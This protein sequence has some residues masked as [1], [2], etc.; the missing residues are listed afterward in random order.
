MSRI[1]KITVQNLKAISELSIDFNGCTAIITGKNNSGKSSFLKTMVD[2]I[3][4]LKP[5]L[6][7]KIGEKVGWGEIVLTT[8]EK[9]IWVF[10]TK[11]DK[12][13]YI[14]EKDIK[15]SLTKDIASY[16][17]PKTFDVDK[18]LNS[19]P[20]Q[21]KEVLEKLTGIEFS[22]INQ[23]LEEAVEQRKFFNKQY[24]IEQAK[25]QYINKEIPTEL[26]STDSL[27]LELNS[28]E[29]H[30]LQYKQV[31]KEVYYR[32]EK[33]AGNETEIS[34]LEEMIK[35]LRMKNNGIE[36]E[37]RKGQNWL[38][39]DIN[40]PKN[41]K[42]QLEGEIQVIKEKNKMI[43]ENNKAREQDKRIDQARLNAENLDMEVKRIEAEKLDVIHNSKMPEGFG[44]SENGITYNGFDFTKEQLSS[45]GIY[46]AA[47]KL[48]A[49][50]LG[51]V[52]TLHFDASFL[53]KNSLGEIEK[54][55]EDN[56]LQL[57]IERPDFEGGEITYE[58]I[59]NN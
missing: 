56:S 49:I 3:K 35:D 13:T 26:I 37:I 44:F 29:V 59:Q 57:L 47:L 39:K 42:E 48:A 33:K 1:K 28:I 2:R 17:F 14:T 38:D 11:G 43:E 40:K 32:K 51:E 19:P 53:D 22:E 10:D 54:W 7:L 15:T 21:Q 27:L 55:A 50:G 46:I 36:L 45:S 6:I 9:F 52:K 16:Y 30:N 18:F 5:E 4:G 8:G 58:L 20:K 23:K 34:K 24:Q 41:N 12:L 31:E 25:A